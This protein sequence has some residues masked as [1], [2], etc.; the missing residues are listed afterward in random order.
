MIAELG[1]ETAR[2]LLAGKDAL[3]PGGS[4][5]TTWTN[6]PAAKWDGVDCDSGILYRM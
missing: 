6:S 1:G 3:D 4:V 5:L 2:I